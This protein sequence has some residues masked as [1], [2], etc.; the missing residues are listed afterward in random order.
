MSHLFK[1][2]YL[3]Y[4][5]ECILLAIVIGAISVFFIETVHY[6]FSLFQ[7][8]EHTIGWWL[9]VYTPLLMT[10]IVF[11]LKRYFPEAEGSGIPQSLAISRMKF[12]NLEEHFR[13]RAIFS[14]IL[15]ISLGTLSGGT[16]G[17]EGATVQIGASIMDIVGKNF[18]ELRRR[19][20]LV[21]GAAAGLACAFNTPLGGIVFVFEEL[22]KS[23]KIKFKFLAITC[24]AV[25][26]V[27]ATG[28]LGNY[29]YFGRV[30]REH[31]EYNQ[32]IYLVAIIIGIIA[33]VFS[34]LFTIS[35]KK[36]MLDDSKLVRWRKKNP[37]KNALICGVLVAIIGI[38][39]H[40]LSF[41][42]GYYESRLA[43]S[44]Q[45]NLP[46]Y[47]VFAKMGSAILTTN[48]GI[49][50]GYFATALSIG[51]GVGGLVHTFFAISNP[52][53][54]Y[55]LGMV[56]FLAAL[57]RA[58]ATAIVMVLEI[59]SSQVFVLPIIVAAIVSNVV[60]K[61]WGKGLYEYQIQ[62]YIK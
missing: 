26:C 55:L 8:I 19:F 49:P 10:G 15:L 9:V 51:N 25:S 52:Q 38:L 48:A 27:V 46:F 13:I 17:R 29:S 6:S 61:L 56:A 50:G 16:L 57:T 14:K 4:N 37:Y 23:S 36:L 7:L 32:S 58:P 21:I 5:L 11:L 18:S 59:T 53:Q 54:Y 2:N 39:S 24:V 40:G 20:F 41:G 45:M 35:V 33:G 47:Y 43:L 1:K 12:E 34:V 3:K 28:I 30:S 31:L 60:A 62:K 44:G 42:N 22:I